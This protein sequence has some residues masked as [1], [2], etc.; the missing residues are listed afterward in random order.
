MN[1]VCHLAPQL[2]MHDCSGVVS[3]LHDQHYSFCVNGDIVHPVEI[4]EVN[5]KKI[6]VL[7]NERPENMT[8]KLPGVFDTA[9]L[10]VMNHGGHANSCVLKELHS[11]G[12]AQANPPVR[13]Y[14]I[15]TKTQ[16]FSTI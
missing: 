10:A 14:K 15:G 11:D 16:T 4:I 13:F 1:A 6:L 9:V 7:S 3:N 2:Q 8:I 12:H 5:G